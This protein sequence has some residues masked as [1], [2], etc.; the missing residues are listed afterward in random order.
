MYEYDVVQAGKTSE[1]MKKQWQDPA[2]RARMVE[3]AKERKRCTDCKQIYAKA[4]D[5]YLSC[6]VKTFRVLTGG[7]FACGDSFEEKD[8]KV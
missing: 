3:V 4:L 6:R 1:R 2:Y 8:G 5:K 7:E